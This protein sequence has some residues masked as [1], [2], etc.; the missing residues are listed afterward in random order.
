[1]F[2]LYLLIKIFDV[3][4]FTNAMW[5]IVLNFPFFIIVMLCVYL[6]N[7]CKGL[8]STK[9]KKCALQKDKCQVLFFW[10]TYLIQTRKM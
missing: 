2:K 3:L 5:S 4:I 9:L 8:F 6:G 1:M 7:L 10:A